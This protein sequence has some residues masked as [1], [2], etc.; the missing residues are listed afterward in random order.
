MIRKGT[1]TNRKQVDMLVTH[2]ENIK[3]GVT[4]LFTTHALTNNIS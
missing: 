3:P 2:I 4:R 1:V